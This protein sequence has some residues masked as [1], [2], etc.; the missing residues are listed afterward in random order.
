MAKKEKAIYAPGELDRIRNNLGSIDK[1]EAR[2]LA[3]KLGGEVGYERSETQEQLRNKTKR[4]RHE[5][6]DVKIGD[7]PSSANR[8]PKHKVELASESAEAQGRGKQ[9]RG[10]PADLS[11]D[12]SVP[13]KA[14]YWD[15]V[16][17]DK[18][19]A[20]PEF[21]IK[22]PSQ[23]FVSMI[24]IFGEPP[25]YVSHN[26]VNRRIGEYY[27]KIET[28]VLATRSLFP[29]NNLMRNKQVKKTAPLA[30]VILDTIRYWNIERISGELARLQAHPRNV[31]TSDCSDILRAI[32]KPILI[33]D[34]LDMDTH[35]RAAYKILYKLL[36]IENPMEAQDKFQGFIR[37]AVSSYSEIR[38]EIRFRLYP[39][40]LKLV[41]SKWI[42]Y[43]D[44]FSERQNRIMAFLNISES[45]QIDPSQI[46]S[47]V[48]NKNSDKEKTPEEEE[49]LIE[50][51]A[52]EKEETEEAKTKR[53][54][55]EA[56]KKALDRGLHTLEVLFPKAG[57]D[58][59]STFPD[60]YPYFVDIFGLKK[61]I[62]NIAP[63]DPLLQIFILMRTIEELAFGLRY[64]SF[65]SV[66]GSDGNP[67]RIDEILAGILNNWHY[68][69]E[70]SFEKEYLPRLTEYIRILESSPENRTSAYAKKILTDLH[71]TKRL[72][73]LPY[74]K[75]ESLTA[76]SFQKKDVI[77]IYP[78]I[79]KLRKYLTAVA[80]GIEAG[81]RAGG[82]EKHAPCDGIDNPWEPY[83]FQVPNP[84]SI[85]LD[86]LMNSKNKNNA[87]LVFFTLAVTVVLDYLVNNEE[88]WAYA[89]R[90]GPLFRSVNGEGVQPLTGVDTFVDAEAI[91]KASL[92]KLTKQA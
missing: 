87:S 13:V 17:L 58:R 69:I 39:L 33:M 83:V 76:P 60:L 41:S 91:F 5:R 75:F 85:R 22:S 57:W 9:S 84:V 2:R 55:A 89:S 72:Y 44:F 7:R 15:R 29:R 51:E 24:S 35:I 54:A 18:Y 61:G 78:E 59:L 65:G 12:P 40:F 6:V 36:Y 4:V 3:E 56:E 53:V 47:I 66:P 63:T 50:E 19:A 1:E 77:P 31:K 73:F 21:D 88:S 92:K 62:V 68:Y 42:P 48:D 82:A 11:D 86:A 79:K 90:P 30:F 71:W 52:E 8:L 23:V 70:F 45:D 49:E 43:E 74:Y 10:K 20:Q 37:S 81:N 16:K 32:Y 26:F 80:V 38:R 28:L 34:H 64:V 25:D 14:G 46:N 27:K 67:E